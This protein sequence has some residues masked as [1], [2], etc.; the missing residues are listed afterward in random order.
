MSDIKKLK[1]LLDGAKII[2]IGESK[3]PESLCAFCVERGDERISFTLYATDL[4]HWVGDIVRD[5]LYDSMTDMFESIYNHVYG[6]QKIIRHIEEPGLMGYFKCDCGEIF[7]V[8]EK[9]V[10]IDYKNILKDDATMARVAG[11]LSYGAWISNPKGLLVELK[12]D[13]DDCDNE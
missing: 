9:D 5:G 7:I 11:F 3:N 10:N 1:S 13:E 6:C 2:S 8:S 4:G 12:F